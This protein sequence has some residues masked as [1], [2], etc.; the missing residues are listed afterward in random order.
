MLNNK[1]IIITVHYLVYGAPQALREYLMNERVGELLF[2]AHPLY[3]EGTDL[4][5]QELIKAGQSISKKTSPLRTKISVLNYFLEA[6]LTA[7]WVLKQK[8]KFDV[9]FGADCLNALAG[10]WLR[11]LGKTKKVIF[12]TIDFSPERFSQPLL[13]K[14]YHQ[15]EKFCVKHADE[16]WDV[17]PRVAEGR[18]KFLGLEYATKCRVVPIGIWFDKVK[19]RP[20]SEIKKHQLLFLGHLLEKQGAQLVLAAMP[21]IIKEIPDFHFLIIGGGPYEEELKKIAANLQLNDHVTFTGW[22]KEREKLDVLVP[23]S[24]CAIAPYDPTKAGYTYFA[25]PT[26][27]KDYLSAGLPV[28]LTDVAHNARELEKEGCGIVIGY[29]QEDIA[30][31]VTQMLKDETM[32]QKYRDNAVR[33]IDQYDWSKLF[34]RQFTSLFPNP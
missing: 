30:R 10:I 17:S 16:V 19:R 18:K 5:Y 12:Y 2:I 1:R 29:N 25:D 13:N 21:E 14:I 24:A 3:A 11:W 27:I 33:Y 26:K 7:W 23:E 6:L 28:M 4:S 34:N 31:A 15:I 8:G 22:V 20:F 9:F 32:L